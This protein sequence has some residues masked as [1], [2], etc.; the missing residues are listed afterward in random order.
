MLSALG[1]FPIAFDNGTYVILN[2]TGGMV[3]TLVGLFLYYQQGRASEVKD[4]LKRGFDPRK[5]RRVWWLPLLL[6]YPLI[7]GCALALGILA[8]GPVP[9]FAVLQQWW[10]IPIL[11]LV[12]FIPIS[13]AIREEFGWRGFGLEAL[14]G[15]W[16]AL[17][18]SI[19]VGLAWGIWHIPLMVFPIAV[20]VYARIPL[21]VFITNSILLSIL[22]T[23]FLN[24]N[25]R[26]ILTA[27]VFH[28]MINLSPQIFPYAQTDLGV[29]FN[30]VLNLLV[31]VLVISRYGY[32]TLSKE[33]WE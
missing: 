9:A 2:V 12:G 30:M 29:Y 5:I 10:L 14:Q 33:S 7:N 13:N 6:L 16:N 25:S 32:Q 20:D 22:M 27:I 18:S 3:P 21:W 17:T 28:V 31:V 4:V 1:L 23:W 8:G 19:L 11:F 24:S 15:R 26:S